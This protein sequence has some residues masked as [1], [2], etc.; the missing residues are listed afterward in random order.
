[1]IKIGDILE[2]KISMNASGSAYLVSEDIP[3]DVYI[4]KSKTNKALHLDKVRI[5]IIIGQGRAVEGEVL[6]IV[7]RF[8]TEFVGTIQIS[9]KFAFFVPDSNKLTVDFFIPL[10]KTLGA[11]HGQKVV[12]KLTEWRDKAKN[13]NGEIVRVIGNSGE[14]ETEM[15]S[16]L[17]EYGLP[18]DFPDD[19]IAE[20]EAISEEILQ[21]EIDKRRDMRDVLTFT[22]DPHDAKDFDDAL[23]VQWVNGVLEVGVHIAD[24]SHY[25]RPETELDR[26][27]FAR[28]TSVYLV[29]RCVSMIP[30][31]LSNGLCSLRPHED[32]LCFSVVFKIDQ[33]GHV[34]DEWFGRTVI[35]S[36]HR[37]TYEEAQ[38]IIEWDKSSGEGLVLGHGIEIKSKDKRMWTDAKF[39]REIT[40]SI[41]T[42]DKYAKKMRKVRF[43]KGSIS[44]DK[45]EVRFKLDENNKP[46][47]IIFK[48]GKDSN[49]LIEE[50]ML[51][52]N[53]HVAQFINQKGLPMVNR[54]HDKPDEAKLES[55]KDFIHQFGYDIKIET[56]EETTKTLNKLLRD[57]RGTSEEEMITNLVV[58][59]M[60][61][62][63]YRTKNIGHYGLGFKHYAHFTSPIR[64]YPDVI[65]HRLLALYLDDTRK[66]NPNIAKLD[67]KCVH[68]SEREKKAQKAERDSIK[69]MQCVYMSDKI[70]KVYKGMIT[71]VAEFGLFITIEENGCD[72]LIKLSDIMGDTFVAETDN[73]RVRG[74]KTGAYLRLG[75]E[76]HVV[77]TSVDIEKKNVNLSLIN[78]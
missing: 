15:H 66:T 50:Y 53:R 48:V 5:K 12:A 56:A 20:S 75:D 77:I 31:K 14:H 44:F 40:D 11:I 16:I 4:H 68:L 30:E 46:V 69:F 64:R 76:V 35:H 59:T 23:S 2:G 47:D 67:G 60:Q 19:V 10:S 7:D 72:G 8:R 17:E 3:K 63:D 57:V 54:A 38:A 43:T 55:L 52:A 36:D 70:G 34:M 49:K 45:H 27:A 65:V 6:E 58:R 29:D 9:E 37:F 74:T 13:P 33:N 28:G 73:Y 22:I 51:L 78:L 71:S 1:M 39:F 26:E 41:Q 61:K 21:S 25:M 62:A 18:Y 42:L 32:K 24:V